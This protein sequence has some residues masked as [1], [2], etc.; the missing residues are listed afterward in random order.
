MAR[1]V[2]PGL[3][4]PVVLVALVMVGSACSKSSDNSASGMTPT[5]TIFVQNF[6][7]NGVPAT[8]KSGVVSFLFENKE[9]FPI[10][11]EMIPVAIPS[12]KTADDI[13]ADAQANGPDSEDNYLH[14]GGDF[15]AIDTGA[16]LVETLYLPP[17]TYAFVCWQTGTQSGGDNGP[18]HAAKGM[19]TQFTVS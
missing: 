18:P 6:K 7:Y 3:T 5:A 8:V 17:G 13:I 11:H 9:S 15:G 16:S 12:G 14:I 19:A 4:V 2:R 10:T 1:S